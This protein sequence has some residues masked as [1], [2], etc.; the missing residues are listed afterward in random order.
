[1]LHIM[2]IYDFG[3]FGKE[4]IIIIYKFMYVLSGSIV[5]SVN[6]LFYNMY[7]VNVIRK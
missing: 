3:R 7:M 1:M 5:L 4:I 2:D 6:K